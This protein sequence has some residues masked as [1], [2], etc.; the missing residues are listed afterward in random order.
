MQTCAEESLLRRIVVCHP[1]WGHLLSMAGKTPA[2]EHSRSSQQKTAGSTWE[3]FSLLLSALFLLLW[4]AS[5]GRHQPDHGI[6]SIILYFNIVNSLTYFTLNNSLQGES[7]C[8]IVSW[9]S[10]F[11]Q[12][13]HDHI[14]YAP[15]ARLFVLHQSLI[16]LRLIVFHPY[17]TFLHA[18]CRV[19]FWSC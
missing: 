15:S 17:S 18:S 2:T 13:E 10:V 4:C 9:V 1:A 16:F 12:Q 14:V 8:T 6:S 19:V 5:T 7:F 3:T 11:C